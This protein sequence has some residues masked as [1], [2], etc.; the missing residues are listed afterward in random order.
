MQCSC[1]GQALPHARARELLELREL[2]LGLVELGVE[3]LDLPRDL[4]VVRQASRKFPE[5]AAGFLLQDGLPYQVV[6]TPVYVQSGRGPALLNVLV[7]G[8][9]VD[10]SV[11]AELKQAS[12][13]SVYL[14]SGSWLAPAVQVKLLR[15]MRE[16]IRGSKRRVMVVDSRESGS[17]TEPAINLPSSSCS[18]CSR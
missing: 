9:L 16:S 15:L 8:Y 17:C 12:G 6:V 1:Q 3:Q 13:G 14:A 5:Q 7:A 10:D 4:P 18:S 2:S 11:L